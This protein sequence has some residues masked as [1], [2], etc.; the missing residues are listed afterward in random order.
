M[1]Q[2]GKRLILAPG[3]SLPADFPAALD[4]A[5]DAAQD[6]QAMLVSDSKHLIATKSSHYIQIQQP[7]LVIDAIRDVVNAVRYP[8]SW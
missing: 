6:A 2:F 3:Q 1:L 5:W 4:K 7:K 8:T